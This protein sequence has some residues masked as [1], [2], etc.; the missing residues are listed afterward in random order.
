MRCGVLSF[1][2]IVRRMLMVYKVSTFQNKSNIMSAIFHRE[3]KIKENLSYFKESQRNIY[4]ILNTM[5][6]LVLRSSKHR[7]DH[8]MILT[9]ICECEVQNVKIKGYL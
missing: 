7:R 4:F 2:I 9:F 1:T 6:L 8:L 5:F 3:K